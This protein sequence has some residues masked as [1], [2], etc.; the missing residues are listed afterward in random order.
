M[1]ISTCYNAATVGNIASYAVIATSLAG[2]QCRQ[3]PEPHLKPYV[4]QQTKASSYG[5]AYLNIP[6]LNISMQPF[7]LIFLF[8]MVITQA[9]NAQYADIKKFERLITT[10]I[11]FNEPKTDTAFATAFAVAYRYR[12]ALQK[13]D[14]VYV[15]AHQVGIKPVVSR[16]D[17][18][19]LLQKANS[20]HINWA[21]KAAII[22]LP[23][24]T[25]ILPVF[26]KSAASNSAHLQV[27]ISIFWNHIWLPLYAGNPWPPP[28]LVLLPPQLMLLKQTNHSPF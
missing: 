1:A 25:F 24:V 10:S 13:V 17:Y 2:H 28:G 7:R 18:A 11:S 6:V 5:G 4:M 22:N 19:H 14:S 15:L 9:A 27:P 3:W 21:S 16:Q 23:S 26:V 8:Y 12:K 20:N